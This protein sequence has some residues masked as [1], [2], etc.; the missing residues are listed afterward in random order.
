MTGVSSTGCGVDLDIAGDFCSLADAHCNT[1]SSFL[2]AGPP[3]RSPRRR[4]VA[5]QPPSLDLA[6]AA[7]VI[8]GK[9]WITQNFLW[10]IPD[11]GTHL[12]LHPPPLLLPTPLPLPY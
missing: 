6:P 10:V 3:R 4:R 1:L 2:L 9:R 5:E 12:L 8:T 11:Y 7:G